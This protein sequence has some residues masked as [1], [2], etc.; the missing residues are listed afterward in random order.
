MTKDTNTPHELVT[1]SGFETGQTVADAICDILLA[2]AT[3]DAFDA[4]V[5]AAFAG[6]TS[7][8]AELAQQFGV[9]MK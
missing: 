5:G 1:A 7:R 4:F 8:A 9:V 2:G 3:P 6:F